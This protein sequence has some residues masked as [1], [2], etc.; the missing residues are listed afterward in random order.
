MAVN[1]PDILKPQLLKQQPRQDDALGQF[2][3][4][5][6]NLLH[7]PSDVGD[8]TQQMSR[9]LSDAGVKLTSEGPVQIR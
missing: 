9:L 5:A 6:R 3:G 4:P 2:L 7:I 1:R 8:R